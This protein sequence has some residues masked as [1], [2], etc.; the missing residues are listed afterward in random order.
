M[1]YITTCGIRNFYNE[2]DYNIMVIHGESHEKIAS[3]FSMSDDEIKRYF[4]GD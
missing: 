2:K 3:L 1:R 4:N